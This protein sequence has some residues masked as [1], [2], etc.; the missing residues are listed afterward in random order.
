MAQYLFSEQYNT[1]RNTVPFDEIRLEYFEPAI[2]EGIRLHK[3]E[4]DEITDNAATPSFTNTIEAYERSGRLL[5]HVA[6]VF[7]NLLSAETSDE[8]QT[9]AQKLIPQID[10][11]TND[12]NLNEK[13]FARIKA[14]YEQYATAREI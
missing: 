2:L 1:P 8:M 5:D 9:L 3:Q 13:L 10:Q 11:H 6:T 4:I 14:V 12:I 7:D